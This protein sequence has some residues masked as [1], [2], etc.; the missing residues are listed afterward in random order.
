MRHPL[1]APDLREL[2]QECDA[3]SL[4]EFFSPHH[5]AE[6]AELL[7]DLEPNETL[8]VLNLLDDRA[9][10][11]IF[12][13]LDPPLQDGVAALMERGSLAKL[14]TN[15]SHDERADLVERLPPERVEQI[16]P[17]L[18]RAEREDIRLLT[19]QD[20]G[21]AGAVMTSD[22]ATLSPDL[23]AAAAIDKL[24]H[25]APDRET[26]YYCYVIDEQ[27]RLIGF[28]SLKDLILAPPARR[29]ADVMQR[30]VV[31]GRVDEDREQIAH[32]LGEYD[33][34][35]LPIIDAD[36]RIVGIVTHDDVLDVIVDE[37][38]E[39]VQRLGGMTPLAEGYLASS[40]FELWSKRAFWLTIL[41][42]GGFLTTSALTYFEDFFKKVPPLV[43][44]M[45]LIL[46]AGGNCGSQSTTLITRALA[47]GE[48]TPAAWF[49]VLWHEVLMG[50]SLGCAL[51][52]V[53]FARV[54]LTPENAFRG[55][56][57]EEI[58]VL[59]IAK[60]VA[61]GV[62]VVVV[63]GNLVGALLPLL[64]KRLGFDPALMSNPVVASLVDATGIVTYFA[65]AGL[66]IPM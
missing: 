11:A 26:I 17:L 51:S 46:S 22:Y 43:L 5:P 14:I 7:D 12:S 52:L 63:L 32:K 29:V 34:I 49:R 47:L 4:R 1:L 65:I 2:V 38:T 54:W 21:T 50:L 6:A 28:V 18:A 66:F 10:A 56:T 3:D 39:D 44:F 35:A 57:G 58:G 37:A 9:Q 8:Y 36:D 24:R 42:L 61:I 64:L 25:E 19:D 16:M 31:Y 55:P 20:E 53:G 48:L 15:M 13:Y 33:L 41:F 59:L 27:R 40:F 30:D 60:I 62:A 23:S 45:Q